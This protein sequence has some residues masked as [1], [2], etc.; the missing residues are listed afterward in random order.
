MKSLDVKEM[1]EWATTI[2]IIA[3]GLFFGWRL[4]AGWLIANLEVSVE[5]SRQAKNSTIDWLVVKLILKKG[6]IDSIWLKDISVKIYGAEDKQLLEIINLDEF[7]RLTITNGS[8]DWKTK[9][10][11][12]T[13]FAIAPDETFHFS[14]IIT[15]PFDRPII[16]EAG[17][18]GTRIWWRGGAQWR[19][20]VAS[21]PIEKRETPVLV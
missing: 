21:L 14:R 11:K 6:N 1:E 2:G 8:I 5:A 4:I 17:V 10:P 19:A 16:L 15:V 18:F 3:T 20:S 12:I 7:Y 9:N 13:K